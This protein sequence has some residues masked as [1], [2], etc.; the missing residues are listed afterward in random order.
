VLY[1]IL[2]LRKPKLRN[3]LHKKQKYDMFSMMHPAIAK[4]LPAAGKTYFI[5]CLLLPH[6]LAVVRRLID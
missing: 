6:F 3:L 2:L 5:L 1:E 4:G